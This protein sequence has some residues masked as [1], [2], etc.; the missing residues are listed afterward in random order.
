[1]PRPDTPPGNL[2]TLLVSIVG[3][4]VGAAGAILSAPAASNDGTP[5][6]FTAHSE[7]CDRHTGCWW[8]GTFRGDDGQVW[9]DESMKSQDLRQSGDEVRAQRVN[10]EVFRMG[11]Q[12][13]VVFSLPAAA[14]LA[15]VVWFI[16]ARLRFRR[17]SET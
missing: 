16:W 17:R 14:C 11:S 10:G 5:G 7:S 9:E 13:W 4:I 2:V 15:Y 6:T 12:A 8:D 1:M 3:L